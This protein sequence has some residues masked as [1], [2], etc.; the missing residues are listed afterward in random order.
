MHHPHSYSKASAFS[1]LELLVALGL[2]AVCITLASVYFY[3]KTDHFQAEEQ[4]KGFYQASTDALE[5]IAQDIQGIDFS[6]EKHKQLLELAPD[7]LLYQSFQTL[8]TEDHPLFSNK[9]VSI[10]YAILE[11]PEQPAG[12]YRLTDEG[13]EALMVPNCKGLSITFYTQDKVSKEPRPI[14]PSRGKKGDCILYATVDLTVC[15]PS[16]KSEKLYHFKKHIY[17]NY[18]NCL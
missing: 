14:N 9:S 12:L 18:S 8:C 17:L 16:L 5:L 11:K 3:E 13:R 7:Q 4:T 2:S 1:L 15:A 10:R 6:L